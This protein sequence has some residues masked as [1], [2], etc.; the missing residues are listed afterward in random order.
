MCELCALN[1]ELQGLIIT[2]C[3]T[4]D[5]PLIVS[6]SHRPEFTDTERGL[7]EQTFGSRK[8]RWEMKQIRSHAHCHI[9]K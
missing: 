1:T 6:R 7:I 2:V 9:E 8:I 5:V 4:C 3:K